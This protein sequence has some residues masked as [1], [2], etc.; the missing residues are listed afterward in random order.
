[1]PVVG[2]FGSCQMQK[3]QQPEQA[4][5]SSMIALGQVWH[6]THNLSRGLVH[7]SAKIAKMPTAASV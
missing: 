7:L 3:L 2:P 4:V 1:M 6:L 5:C